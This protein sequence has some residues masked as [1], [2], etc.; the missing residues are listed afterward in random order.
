MKP[1]RVSSATW[2]TWLIVT[3]VVTACGEPAP[4]RDLPAEG[5]LVARV[6]DLRGTPVASA[7]FDGVGA[8]TDFDGVAT[9]ALAYGVSG[10][11]RLHA[12]GFVPLWTRPLPTP[13]GDDEHRVLA[14]RLTPLEAVVE[15]DPFTART[16][17]LGTVAQPDVAVTVP[18][19]TFPLPA[20][21]S[22]ARVRAQDLGPMAFAPRD[23]S[24]PPR[25]QRALWLGGQLDGL[26]V[27]A[28]APLA[29]TVRHPAAYGT[30]ALARFDATRGRWT[31]LGTCARRSDEELR[32]TASN[33][34][35]WAL[36]GDVG[37]AATGEAWVD[38]EYTLARALFDASSPG[39]AALSVSAVVLAA[40]EA[41]AASPDLG[42][43]QALLEAATV[44]AAAGRTG[45]VDE[46]LDAARA[47][48]AA[49]A[50][51]LVG[52]PCDAVVETA[53]LRTLGVLTGFT[54]AQRR[55]LDE[56]IEYELWT[57]SVWTGWVTFDVPL[58]PAMRGA[59]AK[60]W[61]DGSASWRERHA[62]RFSVDLLTGAI[63]GRAVTDLRLPHVTYRD[64]TDSDC[65]DDVR[66]VELLGEP[67]E[68]RVR[69]SFDGGVA[70]G[71][72]TLSRAA[73][74]SG[75]A[76]TLVERRS[77]MRWQWG[78]DACLLVEDGER[79][80][81]L[82]AQYGTLLGDGFGEAPPLTLASMLTDGWRETNP[83]GA[84]QAARSGF[85][86]VAV[87]P[88]AGDWPLGDALVSWRFFEVTPAHRE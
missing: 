45:L 36:F 31:A 60:T 5:T 23:A 39:L 77:T 21:F 1:S 69:L 75:D 40:Q 82:L 24:L 28:Q 13:L 58:A 26:D 16:V 68:A 53:H 80:E 71:V 61:S 7:V 72:W 3:A 41:A 22:V 20:A 54:R 64:D 11:A 2:V 62:V 4:P 42:G 59:A 83:L 25:P 87:A 9:G 29:L 15:V 33:T 32:C 30:P 49:Q 63:A 44:A 86:R 79:V 17:P 10:Y 27:D 34:G 14:A 46:L 43:V 84:G 6:T 55:A 12:P 51:A 8:V 47:L 73:L 35:L 38:M 50:E 65:G 76:P 70:G 19:G 57:C 78:G 88:A 85:A 18:V 48:V 52:A 66:E 37:P 67:E 56:R 81:T 74:A